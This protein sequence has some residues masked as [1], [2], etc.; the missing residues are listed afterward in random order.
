MYGMPTARITSGHAD[1]GR[2]FRL[3][4]R[5]FVACERID[6]QTLANELGVDR[7]TL[8]RWVGN[9]DQL[10]AAIIVSM[11]EPAIL[12]GDRESELFGGKRIAIA[13]Y[14]YAQEILRSEFFQTYL[15]R[16]S[17]RAIRLLTSRASPVQAEVVRVFERMVEQERDRGNLQ[18]ALSSHQLAYLIA[19]IIESFIY[20]DIITGDTP[21]ADKIK[22]SVAALLQVS[23]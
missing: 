6:M 7:S 9:R 13:A 22:M 19:R 21:D 12:A 8:F 17:D 2:A 3:A 11:V 5:R 16:E 14:H 10:I 23:V 15:Q 1:A 20:A 18:H 4:R